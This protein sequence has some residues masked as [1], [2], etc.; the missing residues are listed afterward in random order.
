MISQ[1]EYQHEERLS[2]LLELS[3]KGRHYRQLTHIIKAT[4]VAAVLRNSSHFHYQT[5]KRSVCN[6]IFL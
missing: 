4:A 5:A 3:A 2:N 1:F 6:P